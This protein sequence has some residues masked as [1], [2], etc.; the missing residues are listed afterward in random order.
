[1]AVNES[2]IEVARRRI[3]IARYSIGALVTAVFAMVGIAARSSHPAT[4]QARSSAHAASRTVRADA[5]QDDGFSFDGG[6]FI[7][8]STSDVPAIQSGGS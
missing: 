2:R 5:T 4:A 6:G 1:M 8:P 3:R 7:S